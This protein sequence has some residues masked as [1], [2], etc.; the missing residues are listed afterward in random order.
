MF[1]NLGI[2]EV[3]FEFKPMRTLKVEFWI[4]EFPEEQMKVGFYPLLA[5][6]YF[7]ADKG[8]N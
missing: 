4:Y 8:Q 5:I 7:G 3:K 6:C 1:G 2:L